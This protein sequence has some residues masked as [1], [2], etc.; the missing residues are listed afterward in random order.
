M[1]SLGI[2][3]HVVAAQLGHKSFGAGNMTWHYAHP[4]ELDLLELSRAVTA[5]VHSQLA[6]TA[7]AAEGG[8]QAA[9]G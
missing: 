7:R 2:P 4:S 1:L 8:E 3:P 9:E 5:A 6:D